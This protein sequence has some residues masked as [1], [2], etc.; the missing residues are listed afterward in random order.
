MRAL[1]LLL[2]A[3][4]CA[5]AAR[6]DE[7]SRLQLAQLQGAYNTTGLSLLAGYSSRDPAKNVVLSPF[8]VGV[9]MAMAAH[10]ASGETEQ[11]MRRVLQHRLVRREVAEA[12][13]L[14]LAMLRI[15][16]GQPRGEL[17][18]WAAKLD[19]P[20][21][22]GP[23]FELKVANAIALGA[24]SKP[25]P[26]FVADL[27]T[28][29]GAQV[30][31]N[32]D[33]GTI[34]AWVMTQTDGRI[35]R[36]LQRLDPNFNVVLLNAVSLR[37]RWQTLFDPRETADRPFTNGMGEKKQIPTMRRIDA[38]AVVAEQGLR[39]IRLPYADPALEM[40]IVV[41]DQPGML[42]P[43]EMLATFGKLN[44]ILTKLAAARSQRVEL[45]LPRFKIELDE[46]LIEAF[47]RMGM[48]LA[49][50]P[51]RAEFTHLTGG[52][53]DKVSI[54]QVRHRVAIEVGELGSEAVAASAVSFAPGAG[55][56]KP[57]ATPPSFRVD[58]PFLFLIADNRSGS[59]LF[60]GIVKDP[61]SK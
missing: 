18:S 58:R 54:D 12:N 27:L 49:F 2:L 53:G 45:T 24:G 1:I 11:E 38:F 51:K 34:N 6:S 10:G 56:A 42:A 60:A 50:D 44:A 57:A 25:A 19:T 37:A 21:A 32:A 3:G 33:L 55:I 48:R 26:S 29:N 23:A 9:A 8:S 46:D 14:I 40:I 7:R 28:S 22:R 35:A 43:R 13:T 61:S 5:G 52:A 4:S 17:P 41:P 31:R 30:L 59:M 39:A 15:G 47:S 36:I 16:R 20:L